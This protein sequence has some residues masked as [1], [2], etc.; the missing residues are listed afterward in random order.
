MQTYNQHT[1]LHSIDQ[2]Y[3]FCSEY[4]I[5]LFCFT[6]IFM[7]TNCKQGCEVHSI[8]SLRCLYSRIKRANRGWGEVSVG[9]ELFYC[10]MEM[11]DFLSGSGFVGLAF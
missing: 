3:Q 4:I 11:S 10:N 2:S 1:S 8:G 9:G 6:D 7:L 5:L